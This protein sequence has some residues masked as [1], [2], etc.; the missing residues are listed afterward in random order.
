MAYLKTRQETIYI[1]Q[2]IGICDV[3]MEFMIRS[4]QDFLEL[5]RDI[6]YTFPTL[7]KEY[8]TQIIAETLKINYLPFYKGMSQP[9]L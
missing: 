2:E 6:R 4:S 3:D 9:G 1:I 8:S 7:V 5:L